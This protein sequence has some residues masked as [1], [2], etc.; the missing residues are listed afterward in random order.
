MELIYVN[1]NGNHFKMWGFDLFQNTITG[2]TDMVSY[3]GRIG[4]P[5]SKLTKKT[6]TFKTYADAYDYTWDKMR[7]KQDKGYWTMPNSQYFGAINDEKPLF[8][9]VNLINCYREKN[10]IDTLIEANA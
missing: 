1:M 10:I 3:W 6:K 2:Q 9:L 5:M 7:E 8:Q 4:V